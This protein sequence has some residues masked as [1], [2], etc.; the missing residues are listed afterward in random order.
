[1]RPGCYGGFFAMVGT[2][3]AQVTATATIIKLLGGTGGHQLRDGGFYRHRHLHHLYRRLRTV[4]RGVHRCGAVFHAHYLC[5]PDDPIFQSGLS[6]GLR[7]AS[8]PA[9]TRAT[10]PPAIDGKILGDIVT[11]LVFT[12]AGAEMWQRAFAAKDKK[13]G[14]AGH[15]LGHRRLWRD[16]RLAV[17]DGAGGPADPAQRGGR[18]SAPPMP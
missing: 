17:P 12:M 9:W 1:M 5:L 16:H 3:A 7:G 4:R 11:Y 15:V 2:V 10:S 6:G 14:Q 13:V 18:S 8:G